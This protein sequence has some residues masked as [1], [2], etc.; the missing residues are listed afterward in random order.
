MPHLTNDKLANGILDVLTIKSID[1][2]RKLLT[3]SGK[4]SALDMISGM[5]KA[6]TG[7]T[8]DDCIVVGKI[9][10]TIL[11]KEIRGKMI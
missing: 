1:S 4:Q 2:I 10:I 5:I 9:V 7:L 3:N 11:K 8:K 6:R